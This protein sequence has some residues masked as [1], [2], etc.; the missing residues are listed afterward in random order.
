MCAQLARVCALVA[1]AMSDN[2]D[3]PEVDHK[4]AKFQHAVHSLIRVAKGVR[5]AESRFGCLANIGLE[6]IDSSAVP[7]DSSHAHSG[8]PI[9]APDDS[10]MTGKS[11]S[12]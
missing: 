5:V 10:T 4:D 12:R 7:V 11:C 6:E 1:H 2:E 8:T 3:A 9:V